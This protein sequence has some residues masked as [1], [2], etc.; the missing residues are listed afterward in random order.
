MRQEDLRDLLHRDP[1][2]PFRVV[3]TSG[4]S[5]NVT[6]PGLA[7][8]LRS[9]LFLALDDGDRWTFCPYLHIA[10]VERLRNGGRRPAR[11]KRRQ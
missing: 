6:N 11:R 3:M 7:V 1:F 9:D 2:E 10:G 5:Y 4:E 8:L